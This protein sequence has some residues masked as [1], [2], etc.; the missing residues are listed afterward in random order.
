MR[1][2]QSQSGILP[3][4]QPSLPPYVIIFLSR[5]AV[6]SNVFAL[7]GPRRLERRPQ[8]TAAREADAVLFRQDAQTPLKWLQR[9]PH[10]DRV[11]SPPRIYRQLPASDAPEVPYSLPKWH[12]VPNYPLSVKLV[13]WTLMGA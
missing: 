1:P 4:S 11:D 8:H 5:R 12:E 13:V 10:D 2:Q 9:Y 6:G 3:T 7:A